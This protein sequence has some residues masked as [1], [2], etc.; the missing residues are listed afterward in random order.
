MPSKSPSN[1][2]IELGEME[3][4]VRLTNMM[5]LQNQRP[6]KKNEKQIQIR[7]ET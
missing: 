2:L 3:D 6:S 1:I 4:S 7:E 5:G